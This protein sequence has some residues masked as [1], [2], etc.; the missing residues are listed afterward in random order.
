MSLVMSTNWRRS[1]LSFSRPYLQLCYLRLYTNM[2]TITPQSVYSDF[3]EPVGGWYAPIL[4]DNWSV[5]YINSNSQGEIDEDIHSYL[6]G[7]SFADES[8]YGYWVSDNFSLLAWAEAD[9]NAPVSMAVPG[10]TYSVRPRLVMGDL[11]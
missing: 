4:L 6:V 10:D 3:A 2:V 11:C 1:L 7:S 8:I 9:P 5:P